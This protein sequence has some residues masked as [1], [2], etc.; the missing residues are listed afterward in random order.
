MNES[1]PKRRAFRY[2]RSLFGNNACSDLSSAQTAVS[3]P[4]DAM[5]MDADIT[6]S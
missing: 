2:G 5:E 3:V 1:S 4:I 6:G